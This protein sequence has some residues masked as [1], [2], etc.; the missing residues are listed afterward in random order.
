MIAILSWCNAAIALAA[1]GT[2]N[3]AGTAQWLLGRQQFSAGAGAGP[4]V[5][6]IT[7]GDGTAMAGA[8]LR[9]PID[10][11]ASANP[12]I[13]IYDGSEGGTLLQTI[14]NPGGAAQSFLFTAGFDGTHWH[15]ETGAWIQ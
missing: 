11:A 7:L 14:T 2:T 12:T 3:I 5:S 8:V 4:Y 1:A 6:N 15:K 13:N 10:F 9:I